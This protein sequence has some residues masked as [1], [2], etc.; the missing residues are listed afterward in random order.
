MA[1][2]LIASNASAIFVGVLYGKQ[3]T[4]VEVKF[5]ND[6]Q[7]ESRLPQVEGK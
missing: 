7:D 3:A 2:A 4:R 5:G 6:S 1:I